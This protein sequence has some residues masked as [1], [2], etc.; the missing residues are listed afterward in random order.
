MEGTGEFSGL[1][2]KDI[3]LIHEDPAFITV[4]NHLP[5]APSPNTITLGIGITTYESGAGGQGHKFRL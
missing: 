3:N 4:H 1:F 2:N 5:K